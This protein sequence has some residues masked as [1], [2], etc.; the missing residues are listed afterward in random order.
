MAECPG[1]HY[2]RPRRQAEW[3]SIQHVKMNSGCVLV[4]YEIVVCEIK[5][6]F[7]AYYFISTI[8]SSVTVTTSTI[9]AFTIT[10][11][12]TIPIAT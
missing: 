1:A 9:T 11:T 6:E 10:S 3:Y 12:T 7:S 8:I 2:H 5:K 4:S